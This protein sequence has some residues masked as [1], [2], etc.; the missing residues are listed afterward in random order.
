MF[1]DETQ[2][3]DA[4]ED[5][6]QPAPR[7][8]SVRHWHATLR[9]RLHARLLVA[10]RDRIQVDLWWNNDSARSDVQLV[11]GLYRDSIELGCLT[12]NGFDR[13]QLH[14]AGFGTLAVN[15]AI[16]ALREVC[17][18]DLHVQGVLSNTAEAVLDDATRTRLEAN[19]RAFWRRFGLDVV[20]AG[21]PPLD[22]LR[23]RVGDLHTVASG[24]LAGQ[25]PRC[26]PLQDFRALVKQADQVSP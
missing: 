6:A 23:G 25:F 1:R 4:Q 17:P 20:R 24:T 9:D 8:L 15:I 11:F 10:P 26:V 19:R 7:V 12:G 21:D 3:A 16:Q 5:T 13:P 2:L 14:R 22:Y 18:D